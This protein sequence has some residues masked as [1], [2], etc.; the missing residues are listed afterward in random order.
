M[1]N[2]TFLFDCNNDRFNNKKDKYDDNLLKY[3]LNRCYTNWKDIFQLQRCDDMLIETL[4]IVHENGTYIFCSK[5]YLKIFI[6][7]CI[8]KI[9]YR[10]K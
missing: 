7:Y 5:D 3:L 10:I 6:K 1:Q 2:D 8:H 4:N 9:S